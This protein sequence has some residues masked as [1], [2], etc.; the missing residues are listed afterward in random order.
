MSNY[1]ALLY[2]DISIYACSNSS[3]ALG[4]L[5]LDIK[6]VILKLNISLQFFFAILPID[7]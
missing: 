2:I 5:A 1:I 3:G 7:I 6:S 4:N